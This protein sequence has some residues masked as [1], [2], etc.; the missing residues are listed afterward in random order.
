[1]SGTPHSGGSNTLVGQA[2][3]RAEDRRFLLGTGQFADDYEPAGVL[4]AA[5][6]RSSVAHARIT[7]LDVAAAL[8]LQGVRAIITANDI[9][10]HI[11][12]IPLRLAPIA[13]FEKYL[14]PVI[15]SEKVR[16]A[17][18]PV[19]VVLA[20]SRA[21]AEDALELIDLAIKSLDAIP[22]W[23]TSATDRSLLFEENGT[24]VP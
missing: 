16:Y 11:P 13:G 22:D 19:A 15:A 1:M 10:P 4:H 18:E 3:E 23:P 9:G 7:G 6:F 5:I 14:Q 17:G 8:R 2:I 20:D 12:R 24:N 21:I